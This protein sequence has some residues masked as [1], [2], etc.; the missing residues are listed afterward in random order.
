MGSCGRSWQELLRNCASSVSV[1][2][3]A[4]SG[5]S[6][7]SDDRGAEAG[8]RFDLELVHQP[9]GADDAETHAGL[10]LVAAFEDFVADS[11][12]PGPRSLTL[13]H[14]QL[15]PRQPFDQKF[16]SAASRV[17]ECIAGDFGDG[18]RDASLILRSKAEQPRDLPGALARVHRVV[19]GA[20]FGGE[21]GKTSSDSGSHAPLATTTVASSWPRA[22]S[23]GTERP[24]SRRDR[25]VARPGRRSRPVP[26]A[27][28]SECIT[29]MPPRGQ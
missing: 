9:P 19:L 24:R 15:R 13:N 16:H 12:M 1:I 5:I 23:P 4:R 17:V 10:R 25:A 7:F 26:V 11:R 27:S 18:C 29:S 21:N 2:S 20:N 3:G 28:P 8:R 6:L 14:E 22:N